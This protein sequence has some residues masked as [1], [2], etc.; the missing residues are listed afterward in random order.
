MKFPLFF[1]A[2]KHIARTEMLYIAHAY[3]DGRKYSLSLNIK[4][5]KSFLYRDRQSQTL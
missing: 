3:P 4:T 2:D 5:A 1:L